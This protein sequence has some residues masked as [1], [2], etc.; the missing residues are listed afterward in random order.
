MTETTTKRKPRRKLSNISFEQP[1]NHIALVSKTQGGAANGHSYSML[2]KSNGFSEEFI[3]KASQVKVTMEITEFLRRMF[4]MYETDAEVLARALGF[5]TAAQD[6]QAVEN[7]EDQLEANQPPEMPEEPEGQEYEDFIM[8]KLEAFEIMK[9]LKDSESVVEEMLKLDEEDML[10]LLR[11]QSLL[12]KALK[13]IDKANKLAGVKE[14][15]E[16][17]S[18]EEASTSAAI[19][20]V[21][22]QAEVNA[23]ETVEVS[24][25]TNM[26]IK[27]EVQEVQVEKSAE[28]EAV[29]KAHAEMQVELQ[30]AKEM[31]A[32]YEAEKKAAIE[33]ARSAELENAVKDSDKAAVLFKAVKDASDEDFKAVVKALAEMQAAVEKS[34]LFQEQGATLQEEPPVEKENA[35][36]KILKSK[37]AK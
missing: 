27:E 25:E 11:D 10:S 30:K 2:L 16:S 19:V 14:S 24:K 33:K 21:N 35:V 5:T 34:A 23:S 12:E 13:K 3:Q 26:E 28:L 4:N 15:K 20:E 8:S 18:D 31:L 7:Q 32:Q 29:L 17:A 9:S 22:K 1:E 37:L 36:A 6:E